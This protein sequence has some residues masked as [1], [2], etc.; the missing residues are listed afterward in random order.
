MTNVKVSEIFKHDWKTKNECLE[1]NYIMFYNN[2][3][4][5]KK[6]Y[7]TTTINLENQMIISLTANDEYAIG[8][9]IT[10][11]NDYNVYKIILLEENYTLSNLTIVDSYE[12]ELDYAN[13]SFIMP[14][15]NVTII[16]KFEIEIPET[17]DI[18]IISIFVLL[19]TTCFIVM[20]YIIQREK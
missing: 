13:N 4:Y 6:G 20:K 10:Y 14:Y 5:Y 9:S 16:G 11:E 19:I 18:P 1:A 15:S 8:L 7:L 3:T 2:N 12:K 17:S